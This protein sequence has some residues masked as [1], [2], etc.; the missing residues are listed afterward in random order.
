MTQ[1][2][3][4]D[5]FAEL[6]AIREQT[7][8]RRSE[9]RRAMWRVNFKYHEEHEVK[10]MNTHKWFHFEQYCGDDWTFAVAIDYWDAM[11]TYTELTG[12]EYLEL[13]YHWDSYWKEQ[14]KEN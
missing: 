4:K 11:E 10:Y 14:D 13:L 3:F 7:R 12:I 5:A 8:P 1:A 2:L 9:R 6:N